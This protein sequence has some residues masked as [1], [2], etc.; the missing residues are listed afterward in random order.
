MGKYFGIGGIKM[1]KYQ[2]N[3]N[4]NKKIIA[5]YYNTLTSLTQDHYYIGTV[6]EWIV[7]NYYLLVEQEKNAKNFLKNRKAY[8]HA[9]RGEV[10]LFE[11]MRKVLKRNKFKIDID[12]L[13]KELNRY[14][15][16]FN[17]N[18]TYHEINAIGIV[19]YLVLMDELVKV[20]KKEEEK[21]KEEFAVKELIEAIEND[22]HKY[23][24]VNLQDYINLDENIVHRPVY[25]E[26]LNAGLKELGQLS[27]EVFKQLNEI[28]DRKQI[29]LNELIENVYQESAQTNMLVSNIFN[30]IVKINKIEIEVLY[31]KVSKTE[32]VLL[33]DSYYG[34]MT[35][36]TKAYYRQRVLECANKKHI[37]EYEYVKE[38]IAVAT[39]ENKH[40]GF[41]LQKREPVQARAVIYVLLVAFLTFA[42]SIFLA[43]FFIGMKILGTLV[44]LVPVSEI[45]IEILNRCYL[46]FY[47]PTPIPKLDFSDGIPKSAATMTVIVTI[48]KTV[49]KVEKMFDTLESYYLANKS[50]NL[51]FTLLGDCSS[52]DHQIEPFD[53]EILEAGKKRA[54]KLNQKYGK[55][56]FYFAYRKR[57]FN[58]SE[59]EWLGHERKRGALEHFNRLLLGK[60]PEAE[61]RQYYMGH[62]FANFDKKIKYVITL[63]QDTQLILGAAFSLVGAMAHPLN[64]PVLN[65]EHTKVIKGYGIMQPRVSVDVESTNQSLYT[66]IYAGIGGYDIYNKVV[67]NFYQDVFKEGSFWGKGI[68]DLEVFDQ[69]LTG[70][71]PNNQILSHDLLEGNYIRCAFLSDVEVIDDFPSTFLVDS[72]RRHRWARGDMQIASWLN[73][74]KSPLTLIERWKIFD[75]IRRG[76]LDASLLLVLILAFL[77]G[78]SLPAWWILFV[79]A[80]LILPILFYIKDKLKIQKERTL[81]IKH[82]QNIAYGFKAVFIRTF[83]IFSALPYNAKLYLDAFIRA[84]YRLHVSHKHLLAWITADDASK[85]TKNTFISYLVNFKVNYFV[86]AILI[87]LVYIFRREYSS[88]AFAISLVFF[89][90]SL[91]FYL[92]SKDIVR[93]SKKLA[94][95]ETDDLRQIAKDTWDFYETFL[96]E[97]NNYLIID[98]YQ[99]NREIKEDV[100]TSPTNIGFSLMAAISAAELKFISYEEAVYTI[101]KI[102]ETVE[103]LEKWH[104]HLYNWY[105]VKTLERMWPPTIS[106]VDSGN[107]VASLMVTK[108]FIKKYGNENLKNRIENLIRQTNFK[109][110]FNKNEMVFSCGY[111]AYSEQL[112][113]FHYNKFASE[114]RLTSF[115]AIA[116]G[117]VKKSHWFLLD[118][119]LT[120]YQGRKGLLSWSGTSFEY[121]MPLIWMKAYPNTLMDESYY[122]AHY[123]QKEYMRSIDSEMPW[124]ISEAAYN[125]LDDSQNYKYKAFGTPY[126][127]F[128][129]NSEERIV[130]SPY[131]SVLA[132]T[133]FP[134]DVY[135]N[136]QKFKKLKMYGQFGFFESYDYE[137]KTPIFSYFA[138]H[139]GMILCSLTNYLAG[140]AIQN[141][142]YDDI[143][144]QSFDVLNKEKV[145]IEPMI[146]LKIVKYK[147]YD[148]EK[149]IFENDIRE[150][151]YLSQRPEVSVLSNSRYCILLNDRGAGFSRYKTIQLNRYRKITE[152][153]YGNFLYIR[154]LE[155]NKVWSNTYVPTNVKPDRYHVV[156]AL[157]RIRYMRVDNDIVTNSEIIVTKR[158]NAEIRKISFRNVSSKTKKLEL[159][160]YT[161]PILC[162]RDADIGHRVFNNLFVKS[163][164]DNDTN[165]LILSRRIRGTRDR[166][167]MVNRLWIEKPLDDY[168]Y[169]TERSHFIDKE[170]GYHNPLGLHKKLSNYVGE[171]IDPIASIR[172]RIEIPPQK[173]VT[174]YMISGFGKSE[175]QVLSIVNAYANEE[176]IEEAFSLATIMVNSATKKLGV[177]GSD[178]HLYNTM[179]N[180]LYQTS[181]INLNDTRKKLLSQNS[182]G[183]DTLWSFGISG[184]R[185]I[186]LV[187]MNDISSVSL[188]QELLKAFEY[189]KSKCI[190]VDLVIINSEDKASSKTIAKIVNDE[191]YRMYAV[192]SFSNTPGRVVLIEKS[193]M[194]EDQLNLFRSIA[195]LSFNTIYNNSLR[196]QIDILQ[197]EN[198]INDYEEKEYLTSENTNTDEE[199]IY[200][201][202]YGGFT[203]DGKEYHITNPNTPLPWSNVLTNGS[204]G[205]II[206]NNDNGFT[207]AHNSRE[208]KITSWTNDTL[209]DD[210]SEGIKINDRQVNWYDAIHGI[211][212]STFKFK[213]K[214]MKMEVTYFV[215]PDE[216]VKIAIYTIKNIANKD[217]DLDI[218]Y[219]INP[220]LGVSEEKTVRHLVCNHY[221]LNNFLTIQN[222]Y[223]MNFKDNIVYMTSTDPIK[224]VDTGSILSKSIHID[225]HIAKK[226]TVTFAFMLGCE[227][228]LEEIRRH[229]DSYRDLEYVERKYQETIRWWDDKLGKIQVSTPDDSFNF[230][231]NHWYLYQTFAS[232]IMAK[233]GFYQVGGAFGFRDQLQ[234][235]MN[236][237]L[238]DSEATRKQILICAKHQFK[239]GDVL[240][241]WHSENHFGLRSRYKDDYLWLIYATLEYV[242]ITED[243]SIL[244]EQ[245]PF[246]VGDLL[247]DDEEERGMTF[248]YSEETESLFDH[249]KII[250][251]RLLDSLGD[252]GLPLIGGGDW[253]DGMNHV[254][255]QGKGTSVWLGFF[256]YEVVD[257]FIELAS[258]QKEDT[259]IY[260]KFNE[261]LKNSLRTNAWDGEYYLRAFFDNGDKLG[262]KDNEE[263]QID[264][265]S[266][267]WA[268]LTDIADN[269][270]I[271]SIVKNVEKSLVDEEHGLIKLLTPAFS[272]SKNNPGYIKDYAKGIRENGGQYTHSTAWWIMALIKL[273][274]NDQAYRYYQMINPIQ[275]T[276]TKK[277]VEEYQV[278]PYVIAADIYSNPHFLGHGGWTW[279]TGSSGWYYRVA[280]NDILGFHKVGNKLYLLPSI[281]LK[282]ENC[283]I[284]YRY[285]DTTYIININNYKAK[286]ELRLDGKVVKE[287]P[288]VND[289]KVHNINVNIAK[290]G[291]K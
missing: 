151:S 180:Y 205:S 249:L 30:S 226:E 83:S 289:K 104:G 155:N 80:V 252:N 195:R 278:E 57:V 171:N 48:V 173:E 290:R 112:I 260:Q 108:S 178:V 177:T 88:L 52:S 208:Y 143:R 224:N 258:H 215:P 5:S 251:N 156:F 18:F 234:D 272:N 248:T 223:A 264:L 46:K 185:P 24:E 25:L 225:K 202:G 148:Y 239:E 17:H 175:E 56:I 116:K 103:R 128:R 199:L 207:Y 153:E 122:F 134:R 133:E 232:R 138:H 90:S 265:I 188:A 211:G 257:R 20:C 69:V 132:I 31:R 196:E 147:K 168:S 172:N 291:V 44:L 218:C 109:Y 146:D 266:Q 233:S 275:H 135:H 282:W 176:M 281:P 190:F 118:K 150:Y 165:S 36:E 287:I 60:L 288:L 206:T 212:Y 174:I 273:G 14:Q 51:Y 217:L 130:L 276:L 113:P 73:P 100:K 27:N 37:S 152:Q 4:K 70:L 181:R 35:K 255:I 29:N 58:E 267:S 283:K 194:T 157:D 41:Y 87:V 271:K 86:S 10:N 166:F 47:G 120:T 274:M 241:W 184:D 34:Q 162:E 102:I 96:T 237:C 186:I 136:I 67:P 32:Y 8:R 78:T 11:M 244:E 228:S 141:Y 55:D 137:D 198:Q 119:T 59:G 62:T 76:L 26:R 125:L 126:L 277:K 81:K 54:E 53:D 259:A 220:V 213:N 72:T 263:C 221:E 45:V 94:K 149:E 3:F 43:Q 97:E 99:L 230:M 243:Y 229:A 74:K 203:K 121:F 50:D 236:V 13:I 85:N 285:E 124:G 9:F 64:R 117:D 164:Y 22:I 262:S 286:Y 163:M 268:I 123:C 131:G 191:L 142:F 33:M 227:T 269:N 201:N 91:I 159:T 170:N 89:I 240:H 284:T 254:G 161:E 219:W 193:K 144:V 65:E 183:Q 167:Y 16:N 12:T 7:D 192:N 15:D 42:L 111:D 129:D 242:R 110:L 105:N 6:N 189:Y 38:L 98:N 71:F 139:Q 106:T 49:E 28:L 61:Q 245:V 95:K 214:E 2:K 93:N 66:Q 246:V 261:N 77:F 154:D 247:A 40:I 279:Y 39:K 75:N 280:I 19:T 101:E 63:D 114:S 182:L 79:T 145:Q 204:F 270:Q 107:F 210:K 209:V 222:K 158:H 200:D 216:N 179:L 115:V 238:L 250:M 1:R 127:K 253:N 187:E 68:Y 256:A 23:H 92:I 197:R 235:S 84:W 160:T 140:N 21:L 169:E 82:Y 231:V